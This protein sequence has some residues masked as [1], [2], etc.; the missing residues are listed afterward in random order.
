MLAAGP[1]KV[2]E[3]SSEWT[4]R[5]HIEKN[6]VELSLILVISHGYHIL[7]MKK[8]LWHSLRIYLFVKLECLS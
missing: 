2:L 1:I 8:A 3:I 7:R 6:S 4:K 5:A